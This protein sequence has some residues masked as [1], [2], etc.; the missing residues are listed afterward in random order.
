LSKNSLK[1]LGLAPKIRI[2]RATGNKGGFVFASVDN[3]GEKNEM[4]L[5]NSL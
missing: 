1:K 2:G 5:I 3:M 4:K